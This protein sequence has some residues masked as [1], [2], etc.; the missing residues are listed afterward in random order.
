MGAIGT[1]AAVRH[2]AA[3]VPPAPAVQEAGHGEV[4]WDA[5]FAPDLG[6]AV[7]TL[8]T[9]L[10]LLFI[11]GKYA[12]G[13][14]LGALDARAKRIQGDIDEAKRRREEAEALVAECREQ[15]AD[16]RRRAQ[17]LV[18]EAREAAEELRRELEVGA[19]EESRAILAGA[20]REIERERDAA[21]EAVRR[22]AVEVAIAAAS[23]LL[24][25]RLDGDRDRKLVMDYID[26]LA[27]PGGA[28]T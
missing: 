15:L 1:G 3:G 21:V 26:D 12:W 9:F 25:E 23:R 11:L 17:A 27:R 2:A 16:G 8:L 22:E 5:L 4:A 24:E 18:A 10:T 28:W 13:P 6:L 14:L 7:W 19:R 20:R